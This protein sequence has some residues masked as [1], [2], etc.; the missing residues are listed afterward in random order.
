MV[1]MLTFPILADLPGIRHGVFGRA[2][3]ISPAP[4]DSLN[5]GLNTGD[6][7]ENV[8]ENRSRLLGSLAGEQEHPLRGFFL[9]QVHGRKVLVLRNG[10]DGVLDY[11]EPGKAKPVHRADAMVTNVRYMALVIQV[12]D[13]QAVLLADP[14][15]RVVA[16]VHSGWRGSLLDIIGATVQ[17]MEREFGCDPGNIRVGISPSLGPC[18]GEFVN[19]RDEIPEKLWKYKAPDR[20]DFDFWALS[21]DQLTAQGVPMENIAIANCC[22][23]CESKQYF[24]YRKQRVT[25]RFGAAVSLV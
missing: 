11:W 6:E 16:A 23:R 8:I 22:T 14:V 12:A 17:T 4:W 5:L 7:V 24:S 18:C 25:G 2:G 13:C 1:P 20:D 21:R 3:G 9:N 15:Q 10:E 19:Y